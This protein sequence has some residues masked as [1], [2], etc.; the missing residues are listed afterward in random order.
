MINPINILRRF[1]T[2]VKN[3]LEWN[4][5]YLVFKKQLNE[6]SASLAKPISV[7]EYPCLDDNTKITGI[8][9]H[10][11][12][13]P[14][15][16]ARVLAQTRPLKHIDISSITH[17]SNIISAFITTE[18]Y[19]YRPANIVLPNYTSGKADLTN[20]HFDTSSIES[21]SCMHTVEHIGLGRYGDPIDINGDKKAMDEL[22]RV[23]APGGTLLFVVPIGTERIE[24][25]A[26][27][28]YNYN[29]IINNFSSLV[30]KE[31]SLIPDDFEQTGYITNP[32]IEL[33]N[34]QNWGCGCFWFTKA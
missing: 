30:L 5:K 32:P 10:Y 18:F 2:S 12:Y 1:K 7:T 28:I 6:F 17:F 13:H 21:L 4:K 34:K 11:T 16:A 14:A 31:F 27:R 9:P 29:T 24:F 23:L 19:D 25:N 15:W 22:A 3:E 26:H 20:L 33:I 8:E